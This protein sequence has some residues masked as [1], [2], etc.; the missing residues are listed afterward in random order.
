MRS[1]IDKYFLSIIVAAI[2][3]LV[4]VCIMPLIL[5]ELTDL[6]SMLLLLFILIVTVGFILWTS[7]SIKYVFEEDYLVIRGGPIKKRIPYSE[8][9]S[10]RATKDILTGFRILSSVDAIAIS[11]Q[12]AIMGEVKISPLY[13]EEFINKL[14]QHVPQLS[15]MI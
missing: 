5:E 13:K 15:I 9:T 12:S 8:I 6:F 11:Y 3:L 14:K 1:K 10:V 4:A 7:F 2:L